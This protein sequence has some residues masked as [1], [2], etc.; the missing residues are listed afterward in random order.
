MFL[1]FLGINITQKKTIWHAAFLPLARQR[2]CCRRPRKTY[3]TPSL[4]PDFT[5]FPE[6]SNDP[7]HEWHY[8]TW[9]TWFDRNDMIW[10]EWHDLTGISWF[11]RN[12]MIWQEWH[13][14]TG[15]TWFDRNDMIWMTSFPW[16]WNESRGHSRGIYLFDMQE[17]VLLS[18]LGQLEV[19]Y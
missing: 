7:W 14:L 8:L 3:L 12:D 18:H 1:L 10:Q 2:S 16:T 5:E 11:D 6:N 15:M 4:P 17:I 13:D 19:K 9:M